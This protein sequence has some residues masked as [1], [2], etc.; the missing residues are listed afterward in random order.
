VN[1]GI[2]ASGYAAPSMP[3]GLLGLPRPVPM[4]DER[5]GLD[6]RTIGALVAWYDFSDSSTL[7]LVN[8]FISEIRNKSGVGSTL[9]QSIEANRPSIGALGGL[10]AGLFDGNND[11]LAAR[12]L[13]GNLIASTQGSGTLF[14]THGG[15]GSDT[16][17]CMAAF[18]RISPTINAFTIANGGLPNR[19]GAFGRNVGIIQSTS[20]TPKSATVYVSYATYGLLSAPT[21]FSNGSV[22]DGG[23]TGVGSNSG[24][25]VL[26]CAIGN[27]IASAF[28]NSSI[29]EVLYYQQVL[30]A[31]QISAVEQY[32]KWK[33]G[34]SY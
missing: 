3:R 17:R 14:V 21:I 11:N 4:Q 5:R 33:W 29:G 6:P 16:A 8:G 32:L 34:A 13:A 22:A 2:L 20:A 30:T 31:I 9:S 27:S 18:V 26:G 25:Q 7:T 12:D 19:T 24:C 1:A 10:Q 23:I 28:W 15:T